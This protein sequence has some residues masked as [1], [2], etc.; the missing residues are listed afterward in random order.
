MEGIRPF[1]F[2]LSHRLSARIRSII[3]PLNAYM[4]H[5]IVLA[6]DPEAGGF[7]VASPTLKGCGSQGESEEEALK[8][9]KD[10]IRTYLDNIEDL[11]RVK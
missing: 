5:P 2:S 10:V 9:L 3:R 7:V 8:N 11:K 1:Q 6:Q 4:E